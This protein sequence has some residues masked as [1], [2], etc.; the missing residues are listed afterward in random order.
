M[1][2][3]L[4][5]NHRSA[6]V[7]VRERFALEEPAAVQLGQRLRSRMPEIGLVVLSTCNRLEIYADAAVDCTASLAGLLTDALLEQT[8][9]EAEAAAHFYRLGDAEAVSHLFEVAAGLDSMVVGENQI[10]GQV[11]EAYRLSSR[12]GFTTSVINRLFHAAFSVG[13]RVRTETAINRGASSV[14]YAAVELATDRLGAL[15]RTRVL[16]IGAGETG[17]LVLQSLR[18]RGRPTVRVLNRTLERAQ[19]LAAPYAAEAFGLEKL[20]EQLAWSDLII[21]STSSPDPLIGPELVD[22]VMRTRGRR[23]LMIIDLSVPRDV[24][25]GVERLP[26]VV[27]RNMDDLEGAVRRNNERRRA[28]VEKARLIVGDAAAQMMDWLS[29]L[30]LNPTIE[31]LRCRIEAVTERAKNGAGRSLPDDHLGAIEDY[32]RRLRGKLMGL[33]VKNLKAKSSNGR[34]SDYV[35]VVRD[36]FE[37][38][39][40]CR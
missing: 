22:G 32:A 24:A 19:S 4:G 26:G 35:Q 14:S 8:G 27:V 21:T 23:P 6:S 33:L 10:L 30:A 9:V 3:A 25:A 20:D 29:S 16:L 36:L 40:G 7:A 34:R 13:K 17:E 31:S 38:N 12:A 5:L 37:L 18:K 11:K 28:E 39:E 15:D 1:I 2:A